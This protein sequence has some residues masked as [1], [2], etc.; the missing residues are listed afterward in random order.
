MNNV[1][2]RSKSESFAESR[3]FDILVNMFFIDW[4]FDDFTNTKGSISRRIKIF[5]LIVKSSLFL[6]PLINVVELNKEECTTLFF[7]VSLT[8]T[9]CPKEGITLMLMLPSYAMVFWKDI[10]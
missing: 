9:M 5:G 4:F 2:N 10:L 7:S 8:L 3:F 1:L 6:F